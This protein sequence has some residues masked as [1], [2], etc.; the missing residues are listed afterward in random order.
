M[1]ATRRFICWSFLVALAISC[2]SSQEGPAAKRPQGMG[3]VQIDRITNDAERESHLRVSPDARRLLFNLSNTEQACGFLSTFL[4]GC[5][6]LVTSYRQTSIAMIEVGSPGKSI[7]SQENAIDPT[8]FSDSRGFSFSMLQGGQAMLARSNV[9]GETAAIEF[10][11]PTPC[12]VYDRQPSISPDGSRALFT[13]LRPGEGAN[14]AV[15]DVRG[16]TEKCKILFPGQSPTWSADGRRF[17]FTRVVN[18]F[19]Q[20]FVF[21]ERENLLTQIT[22]GSHHNRQPSWS[23]DGNRIA[24]STDRNGTADIFTIGVDGTTLVQVTQGPTTDTWPAWSADRSIYFVSDADKPTR[25]QSDIW[26]AQF[27]TAN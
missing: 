2:A 19:E 22:F 26:R 24:F 14:I 16:G 23:S 9:G 18:G 12:V 4:G 1:R 17:A 13:T 27:A 25:E 15:M 11:S 6:D 20:I 3:Q 8:W 5:D 10:L 21:D 7:V